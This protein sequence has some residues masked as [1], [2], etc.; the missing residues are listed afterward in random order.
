MAD[1]LDR[2]TF[3][4]Q[5]AGFFLGPQGYIIFEGPGGT[6]K[7][8]GAHQSNHRGF[9][10]GG[11]NIQKDH[12]ILYDNKNYASDKNIGSATAIDPKVHLAGNLDKLIKRVEA[13]K[14]L[15]SRVRIV[16]LLRQTRASVTNGNVKPP[17]NVKIAVMN[18]GGQSKGI[19]TGLESRGIQF[20]NT[21]E[22]PKVPAASSRIYINKQTIPKLVSGVYNDRPMPNSGRMEM[23]A[24][25]MGLG[26]ALFSY[27]AQF[28][29]DMALDNSLEREYE[30]LIP[31]VGKA[32]V[33]GKGA[34][35]VFSIH[36]SSPP[37]SISMVQSRHVQSAY[38]VES[39]A[40]NVTAAISDWER[41]LKLTGVFNTDRDLP[42][43]VKRSTQ[44]RWIP[45]VDVAEKARP[46][47]PVASTG[48]A[49][50]Q[51]AA[52]AR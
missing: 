30:R 47:P 7:I 3:G 4:E 15:P 41:R 11:Y 16:D 35:L 13:M 27:G 33:Q 34:L 28:L 43:H 8:P 2:G 52:K 31:D 50:P 44:F 14:D 26:A 36:T 51:K 39:T 20:I 19:T 1:H 22:A 40:P 38:V 12:L 42:A 37:G 9:D 25:R 46:A 32:L 10:G 49:P 5:G 21:N 17:A 23:A 18:F 6:Q 45:A 29:N 24:N 48:A